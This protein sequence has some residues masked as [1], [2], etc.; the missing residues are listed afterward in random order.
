MESIQAI[1]DGYEFK[2]LERIPVKGQY[3]VKIIFEKPLEG[4]QEKTWEEKVEAFKSITDKI[5]TAA[6]G[7]E[8]D[9]D[10]EREERINRKR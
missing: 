4:K 3:E 2:P 7:V 8:I 9:L 6:A 1:Y 5:A 10:K